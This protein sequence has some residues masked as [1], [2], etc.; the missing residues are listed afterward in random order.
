[1]VTSF[2]NQYSTARPI[3]V[4]QM[5]IANAK[6]GVTK[7]ALENY[8]FLNKERFSCDFA[9]LSPA[10][11][12]AE[13]IERLGAKIHYISCSSMTDECRFIDE[14]KAI[15]D[16]EYDVVHLHTCAWT[17]FWAEKLAME[18]GCPMVIVHSHATMVDI[19]DEAQRACALDLH[20]RLRR[21]FTCEMATH[22]CACSMA[23]A[24]WLFG[25]NIPS[26]Q[27][28]IIN[29]AVDVDTF[30]VDPQTRQCV[31]ESLH[32]QDKFVVGHVGRFTYS[33][34]H[35]LLLSAFAHMSE[36]HPSA[37]LLLVGDGPLLPAM[38]Q[39]AHDLGVDQKVLFLGRRDDVPNLMQAMDLYV[40]PSRFEGNP[41]VVIE[42]QAAG[43]PCLVSPAVPEEGRITQNIRTVDG[44]ADTWA[45]EILRMAREAPK[46]NSA[47]AE[48]T[49]AG[50][51]LKDQIAVIEAL[52]SSALECRSP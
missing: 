28:M 12:S 15:L 38:K 23:A 16:H 27:I 44:D 37:V 13:D 3:R 24:K 20:E 18:R 48:I 8:R 25:A 50:Y 30:D 49:A 19:V 9:T 45:N 33:K 41:L 7:Y 47:I 52:Y 1:M 34:N 46:R 40:Q 11:D 21:K 36:R 43:L 42:A 32:I 26:E 22:F 35:E 2:D 29:N 10:L 51:A 39:Y 4:L 14:F 6:G 31:R 17:G 5:P